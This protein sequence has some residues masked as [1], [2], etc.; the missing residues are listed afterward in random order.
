MLSTKEI[1]KT[2]IT[3]EMFCGIPKS[4][5]QVQIICTLGA[6]ESMNGSGIVWFALLKGIA[7][8]ESAIGLK[9]VHKCKGI[10]ES[11]QNA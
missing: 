5:R 1:F 11:L 7:A 4:I 2:L 6:L 9:P 8:P 3:Q 10:F